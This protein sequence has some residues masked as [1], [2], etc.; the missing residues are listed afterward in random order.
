MYHTSKCF[1]LRALNVS[2]NACC[3]VNFPLP[4]YTLLEISFQFRDPNM[5]IFERFLY[6][7]VLF[8]DLE[9]NKVTHY[10]IQ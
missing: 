5:S 3:A 1:T 10:K 9:C 7:F 8:S 6:L 2:H 4:D